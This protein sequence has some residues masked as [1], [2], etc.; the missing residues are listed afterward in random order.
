MGGKKV[1]ENKMRVLIFST[2]LICNILHFKKNWARYCHKCTQVFMESARY[3]CQI[4]K[5]HEFSPQILEKFLK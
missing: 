2:A 1:T 3:S 4:L 5:K